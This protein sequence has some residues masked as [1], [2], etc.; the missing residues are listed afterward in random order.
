MSVFVLPQD[1]RHG[2][3]VH[4]LSGVRRFCV[5]TGIDFERLMS[6]GVT[7]NELRATGQHMGIETARNAEERT[8]M[9]E[10]GAC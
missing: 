5:R 1:I 2:E 6:G 7:V 4:C 10:Q 3:H 8:A 9:Q